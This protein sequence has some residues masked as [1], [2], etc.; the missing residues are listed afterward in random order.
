MVMLAGKKRS[1]C[2]SAASSRAQHFQLD[3]PGEAWAC[4]K[5]KRIFLKYEYAWSRTFL[6]LTEILIFPSV[7]GDDERTRS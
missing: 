6:E 3:F 2:C 4:P 1:E 7:H 5:A